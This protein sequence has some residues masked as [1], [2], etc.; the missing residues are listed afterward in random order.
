MHPTPAMQALIEQIYHI[1]RRYPAPK[2][3]VVCCEYCLSQQE[4]KA[5]RN[6]SLRAI[7]YSLINARNSSR[8]LIRKTAMRFVIFCLV[9]WSLLRRGNLTIFTKYFLYGV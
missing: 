5:L 9:Y 4:Q 3:F 2:Q 8:D 1:F 6:T 7:P